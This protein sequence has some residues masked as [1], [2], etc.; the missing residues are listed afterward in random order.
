LPRES[1][2]FASV[3]DGKPIPPP[4]F[5]AAGPLWFLL[6]ALVA[7]TAALRHGFNREWRCVTGF[8]VLPWREGG[9]AEHREGGGWLVVALGILGWMLAGTAWAWSH[10]EPG[11]ACAWSLLG[12]G[13]L[14]GMATECSRWAGGRLGAWLTLRPD[15]LS[16]MTRMD[17]RLRV[18]WA[19]GTALLWLGIAAHLPSAAALQAASGGVAYVWVGWLGMKWLWALVRLVREGVHLGWGFAYLCTL[20]IIPSAL[21]AGGIW[22]VWA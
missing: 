6:L 17:R 3:F 11:D 20:E 18:W 1:R 9:T 2:I 4:A 19:W 10:G 5:D 16:G 12:P 22:K 7:G 8:N 21:L 14:V 15:L 13:L